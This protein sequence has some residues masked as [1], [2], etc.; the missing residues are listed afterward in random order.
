MIKHSSF[1]SK[2]SELRANFL[3]FLPTRLGIPGF[4]AIEIEFCECADAQRPTS[5][6]FSRWG[7][8]TACLLPFL[9]RLVWAPDIGPCWWAHNPGGIIVA[10]PHIEQI[11]V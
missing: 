10:S 5:V 7:S 3:W 11:F 4:A 6:F 9:S 8:W 1:G 2:S